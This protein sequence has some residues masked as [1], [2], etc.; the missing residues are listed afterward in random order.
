MPPKVNGY[1]NATLANKGYRSEQEKHVG[2]LFSE[3]KKHQC[4]IKLSGYP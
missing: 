4:R 2:L 3:L 1:L